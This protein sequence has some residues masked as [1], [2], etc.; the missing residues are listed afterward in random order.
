MPHALW[1]HDKPLVLASTSVTRLQLLSGI[2]IPVEA[3]GADI[4][5]RILEASLQ[6]EHASPARIALALAQAKAEDVARRFPGHWVIGA[7]Q[8][9]A[10]G[11]EQFHKPGSVTQ[12]AAHLQRLSGK[13]HHLHSGVVAFF[14]GQ[15]RYAHVESAAMN[16][17]PL[18]A[19]FLTAYLA[20]AGDAVT[21]SVGAYQVEGLGAHLFERIEGDHSTIL[22]LPL[23]PLLAFFRQA[24]LVEA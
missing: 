5:E 9:L 21:R 19:D 23:L 16:M 3:V 22:G 6:A 14:D 11:D 17:R 24:G 12:A 7:D 13:T 10:L 20:A 2:S 15:C 4:D 1:K 18:G 8:T